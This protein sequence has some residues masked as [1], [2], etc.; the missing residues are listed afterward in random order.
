MRLCLVN[1]DGFDDIV[2]GA[3][4]ADGVET[5]EAGESYVIFGKVGGFGTIDLGALSASDGFTLVGALDFSH[6]GWS[7]SGAGDVNGDGFDDI[8][9]GAPFAFSSGNEP[10]VNGESYVIFGRDVRRSCPTGHE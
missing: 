7:V 6:I 5:F 9:I 1:G 2:I 4:V 10:E 3:W 8:V